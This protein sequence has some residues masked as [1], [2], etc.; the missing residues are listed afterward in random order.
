[1]TGGTAVRV[2]VVDDHPDV[3]GAVGR[4]VASAKGLTLAG[5]AASVAEAR[6][7]C[8]TVPVD[9]VVTDVVMPDGGG[10]AIA[11]WLSQRPDR[12]VVVL[13]SSYGRDELPIDTWDLP[14]VAGF[15]PKSE[16][17]PVRL[18]DL[19]RRATGGPS[20]ERHDPANRA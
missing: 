16:L 7:L 6:G 20:G 14:G 5:A 1:V 9:L 15:V 18:L 11:R 13:M 3:L 17:S 10:P 12:P 8:E 19:W 4:L 2:L